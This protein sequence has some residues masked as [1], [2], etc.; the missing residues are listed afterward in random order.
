[1]LNY[2]ST[3]FH[4]ALVMRQ[5]MGLRAAPE[6]EAWLQSMQVFEAGEQS[7]LA[8]AMPPNFANTLRRLESV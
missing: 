4:D 7:R 1:M 6:F 2:Q 5:I 3:S 8:H